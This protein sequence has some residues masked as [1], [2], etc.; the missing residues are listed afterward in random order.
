MEPNAIVR[1][2]LAAVFSFG[3]LIMLV[4]AGRLIV[5]GAS[6]IGEFLGLE[7]FVIGATI[8]AIG[9][10]IPELATTVISRWRGHEEIGLGTVLGVL[11][12]LNVE[13]IVPA[14][15]RLFGMQ[16]LA[17]DVYYISDLPSRLN[18]LDVASITVAALLMS[19]VATLYPAWR[20]AQ[21]QPAEALRYE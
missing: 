9:T 11:L 2:W 17:A 15:E 3:G 18:W 6:N 14:L 13:S 12:S 19:F 21:T 20:A 5:A 4:L 1:H 7:P 10:S 16:F 8:V